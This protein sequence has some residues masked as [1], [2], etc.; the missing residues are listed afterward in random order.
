M[1]N[2]RSN[3]FAT[4]RVEGHILPPDLIQR[5]AD[6]DNNL[7]GLTPDSFHLIANEKI[8]EAVNRSWNRLLASWAN[9][10]SAA[11]KLPGDDT[12]TSLTRERWL[13]PFF[14]E[15]GYGRLPRAQA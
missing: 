2:R 12:G 6:G 14:Q 4:I 15:L 7:G 11:S 13:L 8:N 3:N 1:R 9:F 10:K 5:I